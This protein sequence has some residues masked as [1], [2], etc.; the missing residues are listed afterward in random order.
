MTRTKVAPVLLLGAFAAA[1]TARAH[2]QYVQVCHTRTIPM[3]AMDWSSTVTVPMFDSGLG[4][5]ASVGITTSARFVS[6]VSFENQS[7][8]AGVIDSHLDVRVFVRRPDLSIVT[9]SI[10]TSN[11]IDAVGPFDGAVDFAGPSG[12]S[13]AIPEVLVVE[14]LPLPTTAADLALFTD[15]V[16]PVDT[17]DLF[18][19]ALTD[20]SFSGPPAMT[21]L[22]EN[23]AELRVDICYTYDPT[24][25]IRLFR[26]NTA[27]APGRVIDNFIVVQNLGTQTATDVEVIESVDPRHYEIRELSPPGLAD[28]AQLA[29]LGVVAWR[30]PSL[31]PGGTV[32]L[33]YR[34]RLDPL[35]PLGTNLPG[36]PIWAGPDI[37]FPWLGCMGDALAAATACGCAAGCCGGP[38]DDSPEA[39][40]ACRASC[41]L[42]CGPVGAECV[43]ATRDATIACFDA[44][45][46]GRARFQDDSL[47]IGPFDPNEKRV[48]N[49]PA[50]RPNASLVYALHYEN[51][52]T[53]EALDVFLRD[54]IDLNLDLSTVQFLSSPP[55]VIDPVTRTLSW[56][57]VG[58]NLQP[59]ETDNVL[60]TIR[61]TP[62]LPPGSQVRNRGVI[63][64]ET[65][66]P[67]TT[68]E[69][70]NTID[71]LRPNGRMNALPAT[72]TTEQFTLSWAEQALAGMEE[73]LLF[74]IY[75]ARDFGPFET[76]LFEVPETETTFTGVDGAR[77]EFFCVA[78]DAAGN[79]ELQSP[80]SETFTTLSVQAAHVGFCAGD[81]SAWACPCDNFSPPGSG[82]GC[83]N[84]LGHGA[85]LTASGTAS[86]TADS[87]RLDAVQM[88]NGASLYFQGTDRENGG[89]GVR[90]GDGLLCAGGTLTRILLKSNTA[91]A[92]SYPGPLDLP[93]SSFAGLPGAVRTYQVWYRNAA[94]FCTSKPFNTTNGVSV[95]WT[96]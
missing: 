19:D 24:R 30:I 90:L 21:A 76:L 95:T 78:R 55:G 10:A 85:R 54:V 47:A 53:L 8:F 37:A 83:L 77:Y 36:G 67:I 48:G 91:G 40:F 44:A 51:V 86:L 72:T 80:T 84:S 6:S 31:P 60:F 11:F 3:S 5:L 13:H 66:P 59:G 81:G 88:A 17:I 94:E 12:V 4:T 93:L 74:S 27:R 39:C 41:V 33:T 1:T 34:A 29:A 22:N 73:D 16:G 87:L 50:I 82:A 23:F 79:L 38:C 62:G 25:G 18:V 58:I 14:E 68:N 2:A 64:F 71:V 65:T 46:P 92:S 9:D 42:A 43:R 32:V 69:V 61:P 45:I 15:T 52:G 63:Q 75:V 35:T 56:D 20:F 96:P 89:L 49:P 26:T 70:V 7:P 28:A 57:F